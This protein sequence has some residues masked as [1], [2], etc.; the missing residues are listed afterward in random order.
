MLDLLTDLIHHNKEHIERKETGDHE[1]LNNFYFWDAQNEEKS[2]FVNLPREEK[3]ER[4]F[5]VLDLL[6]RTLE[7]DFAMFII[8]SSSRLRSAIDNKTTRPLVCS[9]LWQSHESVIV[10]NSTIKSIISAYVNMIALQYPREKVQILARLLNLV[11]HVVNLNEYPDQTFEFPIYKNISTDLVNEIQRTVENSVYYSVGLII[12]VAEN[13]RSPL[14]QMLLTGQMIQKIHNVTKPTSLQVPFELI[15][16]SE[17]LKFEDISETVVVRDE[18]YPP[19]DPKMTA[20]RREIT[21]N[22]YL[23][24][25][26]IYAGAI[27]SYYQIGRVAALYLK[28]KTQGILE[29]E[30]TI[31]SD[32]VTFDFSTFE[33]KLKEV[34]LN[35]KVKL[36]QVDLSFKKLVHIKLTKET[37][38]FYREEIKHF[39]LLKKLIKKC[40]EKFGRKFDDW[41]EDKS[42]WANRFRQPKLNIY[43]FQCKTY[44]F[45]HIYPPI[46]E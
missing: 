18:K 43:F 15:Q 35:E 16:K 38:E 26:R 10:I 31:F 5:L 37:S 41:A 29:Q 24:L 44:L 13:A 27:N 6:I 8:R 17:E 45:L 14:T 46:K 42:V 2:S 25:L 12:S 1:K 33:E 32:P 28:C 23:K 30:I 22:E 19:F 11:S 34:D 40:K 20:N 9:V 39:L 21:R 3:L 36:S 7:N 4:V